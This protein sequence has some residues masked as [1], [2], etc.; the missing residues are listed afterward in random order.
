MEIIALWLAIV[1]TIIAFYRVKPVAAKLLWPYLV[2]V[3]FAAF[4]N[5]TIWQLNL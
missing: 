5:Y 4:L 3:S 1:A 2:W